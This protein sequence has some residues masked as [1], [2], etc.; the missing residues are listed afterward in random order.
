MNRQ[1]ADRVVVITGA[2]RGIGLL[3][4]TR[5]AEA[6]AS[7]VFGT[8]VAGRLPQIARYAI[9]VAGFD[10][11]TEFDTRTN[12]RIIYAHYL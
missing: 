1:F 3:L 11:E 5:F 6:G 2:S 10:A 9:H 12:V 4:T 7:V 8:Q